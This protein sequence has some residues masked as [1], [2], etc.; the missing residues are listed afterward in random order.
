MQG[1]QH[2]HHARLQRRL[3]SVGAGDHQ[4][5]RPHFQ[6]AQLERAFAGQ[7]DLSTFNGEIRNCFGPKAQRTD[8]YT[9]GREL[10]F[11]EGSAEARVRVKT[12]NGDIGVCRK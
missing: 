9:P 2:L 5:R 6:A 11:Q 3:A 1:H 4:D 10:R 8:E 7:F 12:L